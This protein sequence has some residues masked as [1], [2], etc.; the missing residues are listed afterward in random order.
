[1]GGGINVNNF[2][3]R[4]NGGYRSG[5]NGFIVNAAVGCWQQRRRLAA[6]TDEGK[7]DKD[8][9]N[10]VLAKLFHLVNQSKFLFSP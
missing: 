2:P 5:Y 1:L 7:K 9:K 4:R 10:G 6:Q 8:D 3:V